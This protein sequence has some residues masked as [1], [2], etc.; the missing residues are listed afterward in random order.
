MSERE[1]TA[2]TIGLLGTIPLFSS[3]DERQLKTI[4]KTAQEKTIPAGGLI[5][6]QGEK[7]IGLYIILDGEVRVEKAGTHVATL[8]HGQFFG[9]MAL[10]DEEPRTA[11]VRATGPVRC[12]LL[13]RWEFWGA[14][15][16]QP[17]VIRALLVETVRRLRGGPSAL[18][19]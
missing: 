4:A 1:D 3:L 18:T 12:L 5:V 2:R 16:D 10:L 8:R 13:S 6:R 17:E 11:D 15:A 14:L 19:E 7:G 9:E